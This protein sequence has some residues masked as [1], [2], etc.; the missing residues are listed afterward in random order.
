MRSL[1]ALLALASPATAWVAS[2]E[3]P[4][5]RLSL[6]LEAATVEV[7]HDARRA[8]PYAIDIARTEA[9]TDAPVF[10]MRFDGMGPITITT[11]RHKLSEDAT[12]LT[13]MARGFGNVLSGLE[14]NFVA[15]AVLG[16]FALTIPLEGAPPEVAKFRSCALATG[17]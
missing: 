4:V 7:T 9:W 15:L 1:I 3:G 16:D 11:D 8:L 13:V 6:Q 10:A 12:S 5:C 14:N 2:S 17:T